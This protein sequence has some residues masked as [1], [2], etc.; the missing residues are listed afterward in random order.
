MDKVFVKWNPLHERV[1]CVHLDE[2]GECKKCI[3]ARESLKT[4]PYSVE[5]KWFLINSD[6]ELCECGNSIDNKTP[7]AMGL[8][9][10]CF[11][12]YKNIN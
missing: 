11:E 3:E 10:T 2:L 1:I 7:D 6:D 12:H 8:C 9:E 5:G 4:T